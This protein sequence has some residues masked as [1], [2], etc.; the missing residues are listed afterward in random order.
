M[1]LP[2]GRWQ[3][4]WLGGR[5]FFDGNSNHQDATTCFLK[6]FLKL[7][8]HLPLESWEGERHTH[9]QLSDFWLATNARYMATCR[10]SLDKSGR[11]GVQKIHL[12]QP[13]IDNDFDVGPTLSDF[14]AGFLWELLVDKGW[15]QKWW[16]GVELFGGFR[17]RYSRSFVERTRGNNG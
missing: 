5:F 16:V 15:G 1:V 14:F 9:T 4:H 7:N 8:L 2:S 13:L 3:F 10:A 6:G 11:A 12:M 17:T